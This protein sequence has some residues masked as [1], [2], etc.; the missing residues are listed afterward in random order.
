MTTKEWC[1]TEDMPVDWHP[2]ITK[3]ETHTNKY[4]EEIK[5]K[6]KKYKETPHKKVGP[7]RYR[8][9]KCK[10]R[11]MTIFKECHDDNCW[12]EYLPKHKRIIKI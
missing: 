12:H 4:V 3:D 5:F 8:C 2:N 10:K 9:P 7:R 1:T 11:F 6:K